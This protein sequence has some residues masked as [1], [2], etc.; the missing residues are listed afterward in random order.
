MGKIKKILEKELGSTQ[1]VEVYPVTSIKA[2]YNENN[3]RLDNIINRKN[4]EVQK[5]LE[6]EVER[7]SNAESNLRETINNLTEINENATSANIVTIDTIPNTSSSNVQQALNELFKNAAFAGV[8]TP[9]TNPGVPDEPVFYIATTTGNYS[10]FGN[11]EVLKGETAILKWNN[12]TWTKNAIKP[13]TDFNS[14]FDAEGKSL[15][16]ALDTLGSNISDSERKLYEEQTHETP[17]YTSGSMYI[18]NGEIDETTGRHTSPFIKINKAITFVCYSATNVSYA[19]YCL[20]DENKSFIS[21]KRFASGETTEV[22]ID[23]DSAAFVRWT[24]PSKSENISWKDLVSKF[25]IIGEDVTKAIEL[26]KDIEGK[27]IAKEETQADFVAG[28]YFG[29]VGNVPVFGDKSQ[30]TCTKIENIKQGDVIETS[31]RSGASSRTRML[32]KDGVIVKLLNN[33]TEPYMQ[34]VCDGTYDTLLINNYT[35]YVKTPYTTYLVDVDRLNRIEGDIADIK[36]KIGGT[37]VLHRKKIAVCGDSNSEGNFIGWKGE[38][39]FSDGPYKGQKKVYSR[40]IALRNEMELYLD[41]IGG[42][43]IGNYE[44][45]TDRNPFS[46]DRYLQVPLDSDYIILWFGGNDTVGTIG[47]ITDEVNTTFYGAWNIV[48]R[49]LITNA[50]FAKIG[51]VVPYTATESIREAVRQVGKKWGLPF[52]DMSGDAQVPFMYNKESSVGVSEEV[53]TLRR[54]AFCVSESNQHMNPLAHEYQS[55]FIENWLK[56]L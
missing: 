32:V 48:L 16:H 54:N 39:T 22:T 47:T 17:E 41:A 5:E 9:S 20:Y 44:V 56:T 28:A 51:L 31:A 36:E 45:E 29:N 30:Y 49:Y 26:S 8:A 13:M 11:I 4:K 25:D 55:T 23:K 33:A 21:A 37:G 10:N 3:E 27:F 2:V 1:S 18:S 15:T 14:V 35:P 43:T 40:F 38:T 24:S 50:P 52:L 12:G 6:A 46:V 34:L 7:A 53:L 19:A 42:S